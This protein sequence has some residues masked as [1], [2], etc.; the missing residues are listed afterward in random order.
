MNDASPA[1]AT[2]PATKP[3]KSRGVE[4]TLDHT[5]VL[6]ACREHVQRLFPGHAVT[7]AVPND[8]VPPVVAQIKKERAR[9]KVPK[10]AA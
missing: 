2:K 5:A 4:M 3:K 9:A 7:V 8:R 6:T 10:V 1:P